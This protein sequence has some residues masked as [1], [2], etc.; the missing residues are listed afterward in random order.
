MDTK[1]NYTIVG[2]FVLVLA[3]LLVVLF[4]WLT[5]FKHRE[6]YDTY[7]VYMHEEVS[8]LGLQS[9]VRYNGVKVGYVDSIQLNSK[10]PQQVK[11]VLKIKQGTPVTTTTIATLMSEGITGIDYVG[12][13]ALTSQAP[14]LT[15]KPGEKYPV[16]PSEPSLLLKLSTA[17]QE[18]TKTI[19]DLSDNI[20]KVFDEENQKSIRASLKNIAKVTQTLSDNSKN[21]NESILSMKKMLKN[22]AQ[23][24]DRLPDAMGQLQ[25]TL[26]SIQN[27]ANKFSEAGQS[28]ELTVQDTRGAMQS[29]SQQLIPSAQ[30]LMDQLNTVGANLQQLSN[31][32]TRNPSILVRGKYPS[33]PGPGEK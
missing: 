5:S 27:M 28:V 4:L 9:P 13:K 6:V 3:A 21:I 31:E 7:V 10:D 16:I 26:T 25:T 12:L 2:L 29:V 24:S 32:L 33:P 11:L 22:G 19:K 30:Q 14:P 8:G 1:V 15:S 20:G 17:L 18:V 23:A